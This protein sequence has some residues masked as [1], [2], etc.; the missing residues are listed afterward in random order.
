MKI[1]TSMLLTVGLMAMGN[2]AQAAD[3]GLL[4]AQK[5]GCLSC[6][7]VDKKK[8]G[9]AYK[10]VAAKYRGQPGAEAKLEAKVTHGGSGVWGPIPM[11]PKGGNANLSDTD[12]HK[13][14]SW[15]LSL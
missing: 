12:I 1:V 6:H 11:P 8:L 2:Y 10:D 9:P 13:L 5:S 7:D 14:V 3:A 15:V 4:L